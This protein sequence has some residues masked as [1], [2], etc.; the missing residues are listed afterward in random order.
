MDVLEQQE[1]RIP[2]VTVFYSYAREDEHLQAQLEQHLAGLRRQGFIREWHRRKVLP[3][4]KTDEFIMAYLSEAEIVLV[5]VSP[6]FLDSDYFDTQEFN[7]AMLEYDL[8]REEE[9]T[10]AKSEE[11]RRS[12][13]SK[14]QLG[15]SPSII[16]IV[17]P[18]ILRPCDWKPTPLGKLQCLPRNEQPVTTWRNRDE[19]FTEIAKE[20]RQ[21][22]E[23]LHPRSE[24]SPPTHKTPVTSS[25]TRQQIRF[26]AAQEQNRQRLLERVRA[27]WIEGLLEHS[28]H[29]TALIELG[30]REQPSLVQD[31]WRFVVQE[32]NLPEMAM[33]PGTS[34]TQVYDEAQE[35]LLIL[36]EPGA[37][38]TTLLLQLARDLLN[39]AEQDS[40]HPIPVIFNLSS[41]S[42]KWR[43]QYSWPSRQSMSEWFVEELQR[44]YQIPRKIG[45]TWV[46]TDQILPLLDGLDEVAPA[47]RLACITAINA[48][49]VDYG[50]VPVVVCSRSMEYLAQETTRLLLR[51]AVVVQPLT[52][53]QIDTYLLDTG[54]KLTALQRALHTDSA[55]R[56][57][58]TTPL[59]LNVLTL[60]YTEKAPEVLLN[61]ASPMAQRRQIFEAYVQRM[62]TR[63][64][65]TTHFTHQ[66]TMQ[67]LTWLA[68]QLIKHGQGEFSTE[69]LRPDW[70]SEP[71]LRQSYDDS[72][73]GLGAGLVSGLTSGLIGGLLGGLI[74]VLISGLAGSLAALTNR[75]GSAMRKL[76]NGLASGFIGGL[77]GGVCGGLLGWL[78]IW[79][80]HFPFPRLTSGI[81]D[82][83]V[84]GLIVRLCI[85]I[86]APYSGID[87]EYQAN[88]ISWIGVALLLI[89]LLVLGLTLGLPF[90]LAFI[91]SFILG[92]RLFSL[93][94]RYIRQGVLRW[95]LWHAGF[96]PWNLSR[97]LNYAV[98]RILLRKVGRS[99]IF[100]HRVLLEYFAS[101]ENS[102]SFANTGD[103]SLDE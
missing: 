49:R 7:W 50:F 93:L 59:M 16:P 74:G 24:S 40:T 86:L 23:E 85:L 8:V 14:K 21:I 67:W 57:L 63:R 100:M 1:N 47:P 96:I 81:I 32:M 52:A 26:K 41:W 48:Y 80:V 20:I 101:L 13:E 84:G 92:M 64:S 10:S 22:I 43:F 103:T 15:W 78:I 71:S 37:G 70:L 76:V 68:R 19:A 46:E 79:F 89:A 3:G 35:E 42:T 5:L 97:F 25:P 44:K 45:Q 18:I 83:L 102:E 99:Y 73:V 69:L 53:Q 38:K 30:F 98:D 94:N 33:P 39:R 9:L 28:L 6:A 95:T 61:A 62:L 91:L 36:G 87:R 51:T 4:M 12:I 72:A 11:E 55:L 29:N 54:G 56:E 82:G 66:Q 65:A 58:A 75:S 17:I 77:I 27:I 90:G 88:L 31:P 60:T 2:P 34:I